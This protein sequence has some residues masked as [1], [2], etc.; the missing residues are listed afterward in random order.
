MYGPSG[1]MAHR[2]GKDW[3]SIFKLENI[4]QESLSQVSII[5]ADENNG[6]RIQ[7]D[8]ALDPLSHVLSAKSIVTNLGNH[9]ISIDW[10]SAC[11]LY[12]SPSPR[13]QRGSRMPSSA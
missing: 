13:D 5:C 6:L 11:L 12:T 10:C 3:A 7:Y 1:F 9:E 2:E 4:E 8:I